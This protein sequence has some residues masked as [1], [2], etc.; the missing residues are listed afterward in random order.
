MK[1]EV[2][3]VCRRPPWPFWAVLIVLVWM[4]LGAAAVLLMAHLDRP[5]E[6]CLIKRCTGVACPTCGFTRGAL[7]FL[8]GHVVQAWLFNPLLY[9][10]LAIFFAAAAIRI[11]WGRSVRIYLTST[12]R[13]VAWIL[14]LA[15]FLANWIYIIFYV[16]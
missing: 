1:I 9:S 8:Q 2:V 7:S 4:G 16:G 12:E 11:L 15:L 5:V 3:Q 10:V 14:S 6:L 13:S